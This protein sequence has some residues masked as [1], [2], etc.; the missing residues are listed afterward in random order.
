M[1]KALGYLALCAKAGKL[2]MGADNCAQAIGHGKVKLLLLA[3]DASPNATNRAGKMASGR[4]I[5]LLR[6][7]ETKR[8]LSEAAGKNG[9]VAIAAICDAGLARA[10]SDAVQGLE[11]NEEE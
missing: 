1:D 5:P 11:G 9:P 4:Q 3:S 2:V 10:F 6:C 7:P 8:E